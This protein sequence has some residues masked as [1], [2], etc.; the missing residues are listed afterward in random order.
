MKTKNHDTPIE[1]ATPIDRAKTDWRPQRERS[2]RA[3]TRVIVFLLLMGWLEVLGA[4][5]G[6]YFYSE[7]S[8]L[9]SLAAGVGQLRDAATLPG[10]MALGVYWETLITGAQWFAFLGISIAV[11]WFFYYFA[12]LR[13]PS[14]EWEMNIANGIPMQGD[15]GLDMNGNLYGSREN[16]DE[17]Y[18]S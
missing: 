17:L 14:T 12:Y 2:T 13:Y 15:S 4:F 18:R 16:D 1:A 8:I 11:I 10:P 6:F 5:S 7:M 3:G 9:E